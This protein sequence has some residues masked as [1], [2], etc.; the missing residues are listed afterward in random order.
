MWILGRLGVAS[1]VRSAGGTGT[2]RRL[3]MVRHND[4]T[5]TSPEPAPA[6]GA[7]GR[8]APD[9]P[10]RR[11]G[12]AGRGLPR[13]ARIAAYSPPG[14]G[15]P[16]AGPGHGRGPH[17]QPF[18]ETEGELTLAGLDSEVTV[19]RDDSRHPAALR[20]LDRRP[21][22]GPGLRARAGAGLRDRH[23]AQHHLG[24]AVRDVGET[25]VE[26]DTFVRTLGWR[27]VAEKEVRCST[28]RPASRSRRTPTG[29]TPTSSRPIPASSRSSTP[30]SASTGSTTS[31]SL[32]DRRL[33]RLAEGDG[34]GPARRHG[35]GDRPGA[36]AVDELTGD[37]GRALPGVRPGGRAIVTRAASWTASRQGRPAA[38]GCRR[39]PATSPPRRRSTRC[40]GPRPGRPGACV[41]RQGR[42]H[43][44]RPLGGRRRPLLDRTAHARQ[45]PAPRRRHAGD[46]DADGAALR[47]S[48]RTARSTSRAS[49]SRGHADRMA[50]GEAPMPA[51]S[52][53]RAAPPG[54]RCRA[55]PCSP[56]S[57]ATSSGAA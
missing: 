26:T 13:P 53:R 37:G 50:G 24:P 25:T 18:P 20:G 4:H 22:E 10:D 2:P 19:I 38:A 12:R 46:L 7:T 42:R 36:V 40:G 27:E 31:R 45:R 44:V 16:G 54:R 49:R 41:P 30:C 23:A 9:G 33:A 57:S 47:T 52:P 1:V 3:P 35:R 11:L 55:R 43:R 21:H 14:G 56:G 8:G 34:V 32:D 29:S 51:S 17:R 15:A 28:R 39:G 5:M 48:A 6:P